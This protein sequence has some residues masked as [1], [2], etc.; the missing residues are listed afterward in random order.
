M[1]SQ[2]PRWHPGEFLVSSWFCFRETGQGADGFER[3]GMRNI[4]L[5]FKHAHI[6]LPSFRHNHLFQAKPHY[7]TKKKKEEKLE[8]P[9]NSQ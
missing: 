4:S 3:R 9:N 2:G 1:Y 5:L 6:L 7:F 8:R